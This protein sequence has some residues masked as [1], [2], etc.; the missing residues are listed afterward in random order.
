[1][2][3]NLNVGA[4]SVATTQTSIRNLTATRTA[5]IIQNLGPYPIYI[6]PNG[7][8]SVNGLRLQV[9]ESV[10]DIFYVGQIYGIAVGGSSDVRYWEE[11][12]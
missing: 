7:V 2:A 5:L 3:A 12:V 10:N 1:M 11:L 9:N 4:V 6:G 8:T